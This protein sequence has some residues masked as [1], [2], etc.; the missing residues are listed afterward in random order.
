MK[1]VCWTLNEHEEGQEDFR[2]NTGHCRGV[3]FPP[4]MPLECRKRIWVEEL[5]QAPQKR[6]H[7]PQTGSSTQTTEMG[8]CKV[9]DKQRELNKCLRF[10]SPGSDTSSLGCRR[11]TGV[12]TGDGWKVCLVHLDPWV[13]VFILAV[14]F[15]KVL[16]LT[17]ALR[18][19]N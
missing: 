17:D 6:Q 15:L 14:T 1:A 3:C 18:R 5:L 13:V 12:K 9:I 11:G 4:E 16:F 7:K 19:K 8:V 2:Y 10:R